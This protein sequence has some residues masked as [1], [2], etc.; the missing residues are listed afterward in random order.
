MVLSQQHP[1]HVWVRIETHIVT[2]KEEMKAGEDLL[3]RVLVG[4]EGGGADD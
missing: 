4:D 3:Q 2:Q 1:T